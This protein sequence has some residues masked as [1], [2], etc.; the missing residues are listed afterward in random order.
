[1]SKQQVADI[2]QS[3]EVLIQGLLFYWHIMFF[4]KLFQFSPLDNAGSS[5][6]GFKILL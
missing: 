2:P 3:G 6:I 4:Q 1:M 5:C